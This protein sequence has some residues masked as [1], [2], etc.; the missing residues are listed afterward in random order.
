MVENYT[1]LYHQHQ[2]Q[3]LKIDKTVVFS[4]LGE[5]V[6]LTP[7]TPPELLAITTYGRSTEELEEELK[8]IYP[9]A[10]IF[11]CP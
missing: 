5:E 9:N 1:A 7:P 4:D 3:S 8:Q 10:Q 11:K 2:Q 6:L